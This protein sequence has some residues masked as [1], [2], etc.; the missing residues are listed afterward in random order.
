M[1]EVR[2]TILLSFLCFASGGICPVTPKIYAGLLEKDD[3]IKSF[4]AL[5]G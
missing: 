3:C 2:N 4:Y 5:L 1:D